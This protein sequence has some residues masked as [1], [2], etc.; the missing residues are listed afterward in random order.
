[1]SYGKYLKFLV[2]KK[3]VEAGVDQNGTPVLILD[4]GTT[5]YALSDAEGNGNG[6]LEIQASQE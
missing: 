4:D 6:H 3:I 2:G 1:M 5:V